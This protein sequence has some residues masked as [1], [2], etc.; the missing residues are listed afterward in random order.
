[1]VG[2]LGAANAATCTTTLGKKSLDFAATSV[3]DPIG[4]ACGRGGLSAKNIAKLGGVFDDANGSWSLADK[5]R[6]SANGK[7]GFKQTSRGDGFIDLTLN[8]ARRATSGTWTLDQF[9]V[10][11]EV[12][13]V[14][15]AGRGF[16]AFLLDPSQLTGDW[17]SSHKTRVAGLFYRTC[18]TGSASC[19]AGG[20]G[21][22]TTTPPAPVPVPA[23]GLLLLGG[24]GG[25]A[26][27]RRRRKA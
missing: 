20:S 27:L 14:L 22:S 2:S 25:L 24:L 11:T 19:S 17:L 21:G 9:P 8:S 12:V 6:R 18:Q 26:A 23:A 5:D 1:M 16:A 15:K 3:S 4:A 10:A 7:S 13:L